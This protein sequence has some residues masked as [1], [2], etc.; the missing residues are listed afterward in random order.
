MAHLLHNDWQVTDSQKRSEESSGRS[1]SSVS[2]PQQSA[3]GSSRRPMIF[4]SDLNVMPV[5][6]Q[7]AEQDLAF[8]RPR[9]NIF[10]GRQKWPQQELP[11]RTQQ[12]A[13]ELQ[14]LEHLTLRQ[15]YIGKPALH[16]NLIHSQKPWP[17]SRQ[18][19]AL[20][21]VN[22]EQIPQS[23]AEAVD[24]IT[25]SFQHQP[26]T[27]RRNNLPSFTSNLQHPTLRP[28]KTM[29]KCQKWSESSL[30]YN[31]TQ[32]QWS[33]HPRGLS[34]SELQWQERG[35]R[36]YGASYFHSKRPPYHNSITPTVRKKDNHLSR[37]QSQVAKGSHRQSINITNLEIK[38]QG[39]SLLEIEHLRKD[40]T[41]ASLKTSNNRVKA[42]PA[43]LKAS[44]HLTRRRP[45]S[46]TSTQKIVS[47]TS[48]A[49]GDSKSDAEIILKSGESQSDDAIEA[50]EETLSD[51]ETSSVS[52]SYD[53]YENGSFDE[54]E[55]L[56]KHIS[57]EDLVVEALNDLELTH[58][59]DIQSLTG[60]QVV[61]NSKNEI[62]HTTSGKTSS[63]R[64][65]ETEQDDSSNSE[66]KNRGLQKFNRRSRRLFPYSQNLNPI[67]YR[68]GPEPSGVQE[69][70]DGYY[71]SPYGQRGNPKS[72][73]RG[74]SP[75]KDS[76]ETARKSSKE[77]TFLVNIVFKAC[78]VLG[79]EGRLFSQ[80][81]PN[82]F[83]RHTAL[84]RIP[85]FKK[86]FGAQD[87]RREIVREIVAEMAIDHFRRGM[88]EVL[89]KV[90][91]A[92]GSDIE[93]LNQYCTIYQDQKYERN[94]GPE[95]RE[96]DEMGKLNT[97]DSINGSEK[98]QENGKESPD[99]VPTPTTG[100]FASHS[101]ISGIAEVR[102]NE[103]QTE[104]DLT[105]PEISEDKQISV[106]L[107]PLKSDKNLASER[108]V[109]ANLDMEFGQSNN[110]N[111]T[112]EQPEIP[113]KS[114]FEN[115]NYSEIPFCDILP[116]I[117]EENS[118]KSQQESGTT[119]E[120]ENAFVKQA[121]M[122]LEFQQGENVEQLSSMEPNQS[123]YNIIKAV[124]LEN[125]SA[126]FHNFE[127]SETREQKA[128]D[129]LLEQ[130]QIEEPPSSL[131]RDSGSPLDSKSDEIS[132]L[133]LNIAEHKKTQQKQ[134]EINQGR[135]F[136]QV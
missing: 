62:S 113:K 117:P 102:A 85:I 20:S 101:D 54:E 81:P 28:S 93:E 64:D 128:K 61:D 19:Q 14:Q 9:Q 67:G 88:P 115:K 103:E 125:P 13:P 126:K 23:R 65:E 110:I 17:T 92:M 97:F 127:L 55:V 94:E 3:I 41:F 78:E 21:Q 10:N 29:L 80:K 122:N 96:S 134:T 95:I 59:L 38:Q 90:L 79:I 27:N 5:R 2:V 22:R 60:S 86:S 133:G 34:Y 35:N 63:N 33:P 123:F 46:T 37:S 83:N 48:S 100:V 12:S 58:S 73:Q 15:G 129:N 76:Y 42:A 39:K 40:E 56:L 121:T 31:H 77:E 4:S 69:W 30:N 71:W 24:K 16:Q 120:R 11:R 57:S 111:P 53:E 36:S 70:N 74:K 132:H 104:K 118:N 47:E 114:N 89:K 84:L 75:N 18:S 8:R 45:H 109:L 25:P 119:I 112:S 106:H 6:T 49:E 50:D 44:M 52:G 107:V 130:L 98:A 91:E 72:R 108:H 32:H 1:S 26:S 87:E 131:H 135:E 68:P 136:Y 51:L 82:K 99:F 66:I 7:S 43:K 105:S 124:N 116:S